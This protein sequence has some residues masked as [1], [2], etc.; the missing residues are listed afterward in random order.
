MSSSSLDMVDMYSS[1]ESMSTLAVVVTGVGGARTA[2]A[3]ETRVLFLAVSSLFAEV[4]V[5]S[6][7][8]RF[9]VLGGMMA[10]W[11]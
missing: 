10:V 5:A 1:S 11:G 2:G 9:L 6:A 8:V 4:F 3:A 7:A